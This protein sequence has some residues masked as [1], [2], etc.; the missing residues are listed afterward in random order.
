MF[1]EIDTSFL[2]DAGPL[3]GAARPH[4]R[5][6]VGKVV[7]VR[8]TYRAKDAVKEHIGPVILV[9]VDA[10]KGT[11]CLQRVIRRE[12]FEVRTRVE[13]VGPSY[14]IACHDCLFIADVSQLAN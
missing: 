8:E 4:W 14:S 10:R 3:P 9:S 5:Q 2:G 7:L 6:H 12:S 1:P 13:E 11:L